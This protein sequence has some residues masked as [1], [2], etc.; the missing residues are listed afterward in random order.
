MDEDVIPLGWQEYIRDIDELVTHLRNSGREFNYVYGVP[1]GGLIP[2]VV[3]A[4]SLGWKLVVDLEELSVQKEEVLVIDDVVDSGRTRERYRD[5]PFAALHRKD[6][7]TMEPDFCVRT[8]NAWIVYPYEKNE[9]S[10][11]S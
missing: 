3:I 2:A 10:L 8:I 6:I 1:R 7:C 9:G 11:R 4:H 5:Y